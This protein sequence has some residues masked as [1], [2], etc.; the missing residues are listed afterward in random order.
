MSG[1]T[2]NDVTAILLIGG[3]FALAILLVLVVLLL[4]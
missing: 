4:H 2:F 1:L 3:V